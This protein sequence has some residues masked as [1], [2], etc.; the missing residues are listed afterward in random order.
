MT[1]YP[2]YNITSKHNILT[3]IQNQYNK[4]IKLNKK[5][6]CLIARH[7]REGQRTKIF[8]E[9]NKYCKIFCPS[10]Y[11]KNCNPIG[12]NVKD[13]LNFL[14]KFKY[15]ICPENSKFEGYCTE[16]IFQSLESGCIQSIGVLKDQKKIF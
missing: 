8:N 10:N 16:K 15:N 5:N 14:K 12:K 4:N 3:F 13:K 2:F 7:D 11:K 1:Y 6:C 9:V